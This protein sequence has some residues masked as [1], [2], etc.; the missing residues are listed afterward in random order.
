MRL[1]TGDKKVD[2]LSERRVL[3]AWLTNAKKQSTAASRNTSYADSCY[4]HI[5]GSLL[6]TS[7]GKRYVLVASDYFTF[8]IQVYG[9]QEAVTLA[10][11]LLGELLAGFLLQTSS[12]LIRANSLNLI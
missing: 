9:Y 1:R 11:K 12:I 6:E 2:G 7:N 10:K 3:L 4:R 5:M 8:W